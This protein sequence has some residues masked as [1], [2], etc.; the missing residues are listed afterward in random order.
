MLRTALNDGGRRLDRVLRKALPE[1]PLS[2]IHRLLREGKV[3]V[4]GRPEGGAFRVEPGQSIALPAGICPPDGGP[5]EPGPPVREPDRGLRIIYESADLLALNKGAG[6]EVHGGGESLE[7]LVRSYLKPPPSLS[8]KPGPLHRLDKPTSGIVV[9][10]AS[11]EGAR[12]F[13]ALLRE[14]R[15][16]K[17]YLALVEGRVGGPGLW[18]DALVRVQARTVAGAGGKPARTRYR[19]LAWGEWRPG[20]GAAQPGG[21]AAQ[22]AGTARPGVY[23]LLALEL[24]TGRTHQIRAQAALHGHP[25][26]GDAKYGGKALPPDLYPARRGPGG[27]PAFLLHA[28]KLFTPAEEALLPPSLEAPLPPYFRALLTKLFGTPL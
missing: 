3:L 20:A 12:R 25:L 18:E 6:V 16:R 2:L 24:E 17:E 5:A 21:E 26:G 7:T 4:E 11:L 9:F 1:L 28:W 19:P 10:S 13:S 27:P 8:F 22:G 15:L 23:T 14:G